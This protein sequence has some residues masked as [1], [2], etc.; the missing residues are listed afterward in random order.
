M[1]ILCIQNIF[2]FEVINMK[3]RPVYC[4]TDCV[5]QAPAARS[6][7]IITPSL[8]L[9]QIPDE[10]RSLSLEGLSK[11][12]GE[13]IITTLEFNYVRHAVYL[14][15]SGKSGGLKFMEISS[16]NNEFDK[17]PEDLGIQYGV[18]VFIKTMYS[19]KPY[20]VYFDRS[21]NTEAKPGA[22]IIQAL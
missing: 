4:E 17:T 20:I 11:A 19:E 16:E 1:Y 6:S 12:Y 5:G 10:Y 14:D 9:I 15:T 21:S 2:L 7:K 13:N 8:S 22:P 3:P 18:T